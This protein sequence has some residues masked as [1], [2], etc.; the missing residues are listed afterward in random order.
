M[1]ALVRCTLLLAAI[2]WNGWAPASLQAAPVAVALA[3]DLPP[4]EHPGEQETRGIVEQMPDGGLV[5]LWQ[6]GGVVYETTDATRFDQ[7]Y[8]AF[9]RG[10]CVEVHYTET[11]VED[12]VEGPVEGETGTNVQRLVLEL[13]TARDYLCRQ[14]EPGQGKDHPAK[15]HHPEGKLFGVIVSFPPALEGEWVVGGMTFDAGPQ[16]QFIQ[17]EAPFTPGGMA[18]VF[19]YTGDDGRHYAIKIISFVPEGDEERE[20]DEERLAHGIAFGPVASFPDNWVGD[21]EIGGLVYKATEETR[22]VQKSGP[23]T[24]NG[25]ARVAFTLADDGSRIAH[26]I[27]TVAGP[28]TGHKSHFLLIGYVTA[29]P[30]GS[31]IGQWQAGGVSFT[32]DAATEFKEENGLLGAGAYVEVEYTLAGNTVQARQIKAH[33]PPG[34]GDH[35]RTGILESIGP[36]TVQIAAAGVAVDE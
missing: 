3:Q 33:V 35:R 36:G 31:Y 2:T 13:A 8:G 11:I 6:I 26:E 12:E 7:D 22:F 4:G 23:F 5:G 27:K 1:R 17:E 9:A 34:G 24:V 32:A 20:P 25:Q 30:A 14:P 29:L 18:K 19:F 16:T 15:P 10:R 28:T 21:W